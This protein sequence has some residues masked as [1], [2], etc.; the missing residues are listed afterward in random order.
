MF[1]R[2][3]VLLGAGGAAMAGAVAGRTLSRTAASD[4]PVGLMAG[5][6]RVPAGVAEAARCSWILPSSANGQQSAFQVQA[7]ASV[8]RLLAGS[9]DH[10]SGRIFSP[11]SASARPPKSILKPGHHCYWR[12]RTWDSAGHVSRWSKAQRIIAEAHEDW[13]AD[14]IWVSEQGHQADW[15]LAR[16]EFD[17]PADVEAVWVH[18]AAASPEPARQYVFRLTLNGTFVG[19]GPVRSCAPDKEARY[20]TFDLTDRVRPGRNALAALCYAAEGRAFLARITIIRRNGERTVIGT[21]PAWRVLS[22]DRWRPAAGFTGGGYYKAPQEFIDAR[23]EPD[24]WQLPGFDDQQWSTPDKRLFG[25]TLRPHSVDE[26]TQTLITPSAIQ[27]APGRWLFDLGREIAGGIRLSISGKAGRTVEVRL[28]EERSADGGARYELRA[29]QVYREVWTLRHG[30]QQLE[31][32]GYRAFR[33]IEL[34][35]DPSLDLRNSVTGVELAMPWSESDSAFVSSSPDL[36]RVWGMCRYSIRALRLDV[37]Q[38]TPSRERGPYE[39]DA[40]INQLSEYAVQRSYSLSRYSTG[41]LAR[42]PTWP[43][44]YRMQTPIL[45]WRDYMA[46]G[47]PGVLS[48]NYEAMLGR[49]RLD[50]LNAQG[51]VEKDPGKPSE[52]EADLVDWPIANRDGYVFTRVNTVINAWQFASLIAMANIAG[53]IGRGAESQRFTALAQ[54]LRDSLNAACLGADGTYVDGI[55]TAHRSQ[56]ATAFAIALGII[57]ENY[58]AAAG[59]AL[60][61]QGMRMSVYGAQFLLEALYRSGQP[62]AAMKLMTGRGEFSWLHMIDDLHATITTE[63]WDPKIKPNLTFSHAWGTAPANIVQRFVAGVKVAAPGAARLQIRPEPSGLAFF[64]ATVPTIRGSVEVRYDGRRP[65]RLFQIELPPN[66]PAD[67]E[68]APTLIDPGRVHISGG[69]AEHFANNGALLVNAPA[70]GRINIAG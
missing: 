18:A 56:H 31:H 10:D 61:S 68:L 29:S 59:R 49:M 6:R 14:P 12:V 25:L 27:L 48:A 2:R 8:E 28:G 22:G 53:V 54:R 3:E 62:E 30:P 69:R 21:G 57:P 37:Y 26:I 42:R 44:E 63:A 60:A 35:A 51:L 50:R 70:G 40:I 33:W 23:Q 9:P 41:Y 67:I 65:A 64:R 66:V 45:A 52:P 36:D 47:D 43:T 16:T 13:G 55:G 34:L 5:L 38:D 24:G 39:G 15:L 19:V 17:V 11:E 1:R 32:W 4:A 20:S 58:L 7:A 46:T